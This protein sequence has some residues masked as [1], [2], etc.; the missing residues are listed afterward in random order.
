MEGLV[1]GSGLLLVHDRELLAVV[2]EWLASVDDDTFDQ[3][4]PLLRRSFAGFQPGERRM[5]GEA[6]AAIQS[7]TTPGERMRTVREG[8]DRSRASEVLGL[9]SLLFGADGPT[10]AGEDD[11]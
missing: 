5:I 6:A 4:L 1:S 2:D 11:R 7:S 8:L 10:A 9:V 3:V